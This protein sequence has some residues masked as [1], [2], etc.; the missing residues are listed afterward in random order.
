[1]ESKIQQT[2]NIPHILITPPVAENRPDP[3]MK[4]RDKPQSVRDARN[5][6]NPDLA[7][8]QMKAGKI[9]SS[10]NK[11]GFW[12]TDGFTFADLIDFVNPLQHIPIV[13]TIYR[14]ITGDEIGIGPRLFGGAI[15]GGVVGVGSALVNAAVENETGKDIGGNVLAAVTSAGK[16]AMNVANLTPAAQTATKV[17]ALRPAEGLAPMPGMV[18]SAAT[19]EAEA[20]EA[21]AVKPT[22]ALPF[23]ETA[24]GMMQGVNPA[25]AQILGTDAIHQ[26]Y[27]QAQFLDILQKSALQ[28]S[29]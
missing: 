10:A 17:A 15:L 16:K 6:Q 2:Q 24:P 1:M 4:L 25:T 3:G 7:S 18:A 8:N 22:A 21:V 13:S 28:M 14:A 11:S 20:A 27:R 26:S 23:P 9:P 12:G 19:A 5:V 29:A